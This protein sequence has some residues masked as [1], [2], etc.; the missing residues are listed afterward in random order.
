M[1][2][3][4]RNAPAPLLRPASGEALHLNRRLNSGSLGLRFNCKSLLHLLG[5]SEEN[6]FYDPGLSL[7]RAAICLRILRGVDLV[8]YLQ[9]MNRPRPGIAAKVH[10]DTYRSRI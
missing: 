2:S 5:D 4:C 9:S 1:T 3:S 6:A 7:V 10:R 8:K